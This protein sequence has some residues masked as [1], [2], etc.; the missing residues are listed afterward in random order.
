MCFCPS[1]QQ[2]LEKE[3]LIRKF[4]SMRNLMANNT[5]IGVDFR[6]FRIFKVLLWQHKI[7]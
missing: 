7:H 3:Q 4:L 1:G 2:R 6:Y 5:G